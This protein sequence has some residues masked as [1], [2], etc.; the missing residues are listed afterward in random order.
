M[1]REIEPFSDLAELRRIFGDDYSDSDYEEASGADGYGGVDDDRYD[2][3]GFSTRGGG[4]AGAFC[5]DFGQSRMP[6]FR[7]RARTRPFG[8]RGDFGYERG[9]VPSR[10][11]RPW[12]GRG[13]APFRPPARG[14]WSQSPRCNRGDP[15]SQ[16][17]GGGAFNGARGPRRGFGVRP[18]L[19]GNNGT[20]SRDYD[21]RGTAIAEK[22][23]SVDLSVHLIATNRRDLSGDSVAGRSRRRRVRTRGE[24][25]GGRARLKAHASRT[26]AEAGG[27]REVSTPGL[28]RA[29][30]SPIGEEVTPREI[31]AG[32]RR[33]RR[34]PA[35]CVHGTSQQR[36]RTVLAVGIA[37]ESR[38]LT[39]GA[40]TG[41]RIASP[42]RTERP[43]EE[44]S[45]SK[46]P[47][48]PL[49]LGARSHH[50]NTSKVSA[51]PTVRKVA[52]SV[53]PAA[54]AT[55]NARTLGAKDEGQKLDA[56]RRTKCPK[57]AS[58]SRP[59]TTK[60]P[61]PDK[62]PPT[63]KKVLKSADLQIA[64]ESYFSPI[65]DDSSGDRKDGNVTQPGT[66]TWERPSLSLDDV[67]AVPQCTPEIS[68]PRTLLPSPDST[69]DPC[70]DL[71][72]CEDVPCEVVSAEDPTETADSEDVPCEVVSVEDPTETAD[73]V[74]S[75]VG[76]E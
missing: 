41:T 15:P 28:A 68:S 2:C 35:G 64:D 20:S 53:E 63:A 22:K 55:S 1:S 38:E 67:Q 74:L 45:R 52:D 11:C 26:T 73:S 71:A 37:R 27:S 34:R 16:R 14:G 24:R 62:S 46:R 75:V 5:N 40:K 33:W 3:G 54:V 57:H 60:R 18:P 17:G 36:I 19:H 58:S 21:L 43:R 59:S 12:L 4:G 25:T 49:P 56:T 32:R 29:T 13:R 23:P 10:G 9:G 8:P 39:R 31:R 48:D 61:P 47:G 72:V 69:T 7:G 30:A 66:G 76:N 70:H 50:G 65:S 42:A 44:D 6:F 51:K